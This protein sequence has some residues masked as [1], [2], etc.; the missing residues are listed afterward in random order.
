MMQNTRDP[1]R[2]DG[3]VE[4]F[5]ELWK[6]HPDLRFGQLIMNLSK[7]EGD[8][9]II[10]DDTWKKLFIQSLES[11]M[12]RD[13]KPRWIVFTIPEMDN[14]HY[15]NFLKIIQSLRTVLEDKEII[16]GMNDS[17]IDYF[18]A[19]R[20]KRSD[21]SLERKFIEAIDM[22]KKCI[23]SIENGLEWINS[24]N[25]ASQIVLKYIDGMTEIDYEA[26]KIIIEKI[27]YI[28]KK[29]TKIARLSQAKKMRGLYSYLNFVKVDRKIGIP[30]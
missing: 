8:P 4:K 25:S 2:I 13:N 16:I 20:L 28:K 21:D 6:K 24:W 23:T 30:K 3:I 1:N 29:T 22:I 10:E 17:L 7:F 19:M 12:P 9:F 26:T 11:E 14:D 27:D 15:K 5:K 18:S